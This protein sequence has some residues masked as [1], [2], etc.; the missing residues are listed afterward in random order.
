MRPGIFRRSP[1]AFL[2]S[3]ALAQ[4][5]DVV[6]FGAPL[7]LTCSGRR[8]TACAPNQIR[9][10]SDLL[11]T[12]SPEL[13]ADLEDIALAD[14]GDVP[15]EALGMD[16]ALAAIESAARTG[17]E[18][19]M[20]VILGGEH[21]LSL[22][23]IR[24]AKALYPELAVIQVDAH[25]DLRDT[26]EG[27]S[28]CHATVF[29]RVIEEVG[30][31]SLVQLG[32]RSGTKDE[33]SAATSCLWSSRHLVLPEKTRARLGKRPIYL[34]IDLDV[35]DP[36]YAPGVSCPEPAG[37]SSAEVLKFVYTLQDL[38]IVAADIVEVV[39]A[40]DPSAVT[41]LCAAK[42]VRE[43]AL[44]HSRRERERHTE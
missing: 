27:N 42:T 25:L 7:D 38:R 22:A 2:G 6:I 20:T 5:P 3:R 36:A 24:A 4:S 35:V 11:E 31:Q 34:S 15:L 16:E 23:A 13:G 8:G 26:Y 18:T 19:A 17:M 41:S 10:V 44:M 12:Y 21:S 29:Q 40:Q 43:I 32:I 30:A 14:W 1:S 33:F 28:T 9:I 39:P 37:F